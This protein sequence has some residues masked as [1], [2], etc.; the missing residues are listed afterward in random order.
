VGT[1]TTTS[2]GNTFTASSVMSANGGV[3]SFNPA[4]DP[5]LATM[6]G[7]GDA[8]RQPAG[9]TPAAT[10]VQPYRGPQSEVSNSIGKSLFQKNS[11]ATQIW[12]TSVVCEQ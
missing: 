6:K 7:Y 4:L 5:Q 2:S 10:L 9:L 8:T 1:T 3:G 12:C 11:A